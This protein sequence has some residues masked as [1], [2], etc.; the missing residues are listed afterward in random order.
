MVAEQPKLELIPPS[1]RDSLSIAVE[2]CSK[3]FVPNSEDESSFKP[4]APIEEGAPDWAAKDPEESTVLSLKVE[5]VAPKN[6]HQRPAKLDGEYRHTEPQPQSSRIGISLPAE[7]PVEIHREET[8]QATILNAPSVESNGMI[9]INKG[10]SP[11]A[12]ADME[13]SMARNGIQDS[14]RHGSELRSMSKK[15]IREQPPGQSKLSPSLS[16]S[17]EDPVESEFQVKVENASDSAAASPTLSMPA[18]PI[19]VQDP[20]S[21]TYALSSFSTVPVLVGKRSYA[22]VEAAYQA[23]KFEDEMKRDALWVAAGPWMAMS[24]GQ[25]WGL[26]VRSEWL[27]EGHEHVLQALNSLKVLQVRSKS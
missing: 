25:T 21:K 23:S 11:A 16:E 6:V 20:K 18:Q 24:Q 12:G 13:T 9:Q 22:S 17:I 2:A 26:H 1:T 5:S 15:P 10:Q 3:Q 8:Q 4:E 7:Y 27:K 14:S 19:V